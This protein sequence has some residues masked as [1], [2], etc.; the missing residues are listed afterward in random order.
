MEILHVFVHV[1]KPGLRNH[2][3]WLF[4]RV[5][6]NNDLNVKTPWTFACMSDFFREKEKRE[7]MFEIAL[8]YISILH[9]SIR[10]EAVFNTDNNQKCFLSSKSTY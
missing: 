10:Y 7:A 5:K 8:H 3:D 2:V 1:H 6:G 4:Y 9:I